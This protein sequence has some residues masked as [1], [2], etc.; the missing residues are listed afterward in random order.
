MEIIHPLR[1]APHIH[2]DSNANSIAAQL[3]MGRCQ[4]LF[5]GDIDAETERAL[6]RRGAPLATTILKVAHHGSN[7]S[8]SHAFLEAADP[9]TAII[10]VGSNNLFGH[11]SPQ[12]L[13]RLE[14]LGCRIWRT[15]EHG[16]IEVITDGQRYWVKPQRP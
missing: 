5:A 11:P 16:T 14:T 3:T 13:D 15:D 1:E 10:S 2:S 4:V 7:D 9:Q 6:L 8:S 12:V